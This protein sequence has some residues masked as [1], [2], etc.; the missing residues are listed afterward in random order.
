MPLLNKLMGNSSNSASTENRPCSTSLLP[1]NH[2]FWLLCFTDNSNI[3][4]NYD[5]NPAKVYEWMLQLNRCEV[6]DGFENIDEFETF[7]A[8]KTKGKLKARPRLKIS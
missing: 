5:L 7:I 3:R 8:N 2:P 6:P 1:D 4:T